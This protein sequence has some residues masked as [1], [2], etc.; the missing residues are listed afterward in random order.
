MSRH[1]LFTTDGFTHASIVIPVVTSSDAA[2]LMV[3][4]ALVP[5]KTSAPLYLPEVVHVAPLIVPSF[6][7]PEVSVTDDPVPSLNPY[8]ATRPA[9]CP[10]AETDI[11]SKTAAEILRVKRC[12]TNTL[13]RHK[14]TANSLHIILWINASFDLLK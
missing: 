9:T 1:A 13:A 4:S 3:T 10:F 6:P 7:L 8:S 2:S 12:V 5:L 11:Q 14:T